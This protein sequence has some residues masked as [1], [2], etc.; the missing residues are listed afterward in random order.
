MNDATNNT[1]NAAEMV[2]T[3]KWEE[4]GHGK[5]P[6]RPLCII[7]IPSAEICERNPSAYNQLMA[8]AMQCAKS[9]GV[10]LCSCNV[11]GMSLVNNVVIRD[12]AGKHFVVGL[13]CAGKS[14]DSKLVTQA[15][16]LEA[17]RQRQKR[18]AKRDEERQ[19]REAARLA[20]L[21][22]QRDRNGGLTDYELAEKKRADAAQALAGKS[23]QE[24]AWLI[25][26][27]RGEYQGD[28]V[29]AMIAQ[30]E[31]KPLHDA[32]RGRAAE[33]VGEIYGK[34]KGGRR[35]SKKYQ[36][37]EAEFWAKYNEGL[38]EV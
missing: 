11:C 36:A 16:K 5:A 35:G 25:E 32:I 31:A 26:V 33:I 6:F 15:E 38:T 21:Q 9:F 2:L 10:T 20:E 28:F 4:A 24:N 29:K 23:R 27:L 37:A 14:G 30:L 8:E 1:T 7:S 17:A 19:A 22:A 13:D 3:H 34:Q 12:A 18:E